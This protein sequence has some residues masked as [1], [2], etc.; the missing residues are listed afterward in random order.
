MNVKKQLKKACKK[1][2]IKTLHEYQRKPIE[3][4]CN[5]HDTMVIAPVGAGKS[6]IYQLPGLMCDGLTI[7]VEPTLSLIYDQVQKLQERG[8]AADYMDSTRSAFE[9][10]N[11]LLKAEKRNLKFLFVTPERLQKCVFAATM[12]SIPVKMVVVDEAHCVTA[13]GHSFRPDY[14][15]IGEFIKEL[16]ERPV[17]VALTATATSAMRE[18]IVDKLSMNQPEIFVN[19]LRRTNLR[20]LK[21]GFYSDEEKLKKLK[22]L[23]KKYEVGCCIVFCNTKRMTDAVYN[24]IKE[25]YP[26]ETVRCHSNLEPETRKSNEMSFLKG[27]KCIM[28]ATSAFGMGIDQSDVDLIIHFNLPLSLI[29]YYQQAGRAGRAGQ[30]SKCVLLYCENDYLVNQRILKSIEDQQARKA[31]LKNLDAMKAYAESKYCLSRQLL[32]ALDEDTG[33]CGVCTNCQKRRKEHD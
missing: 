21:Y 1:L 3:S 4:I 17:V 12:K 30:K 29:D 5:E 31:A 24:Q 10:S 20:F 23:L 32:Q 9:R 26:H 6:A 19:S 28:V 16:P 11:V 27:D 14:L 18:K 22:R 2:G 8:I 25:W 13:W 7:V 15:K 33:I